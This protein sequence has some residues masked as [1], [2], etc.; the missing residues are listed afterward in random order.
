MKENRGVKKREKEK[1]EEFSLGG[2]ATK[3]GENKKKL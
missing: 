1:R 2:G 3:E